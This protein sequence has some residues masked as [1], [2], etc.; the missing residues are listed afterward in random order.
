M[1]NTDMVV[2]VLA[3]GAHPDDVEL[4]VGGL[5]HKLSQHGHVVGILDLTRGE[6]GTRGTPD[7]RAQEAAAAAEIL[8]IARRENVGLPDGQLANTTEQQR[9]IIPLLRSFRARTLLLPQGRDRHPDHRSAYELVRDAAYF[10]GLAKIETGQE[11]YRPEFTYYYH[12]Y[13]QDN[14]T[15]DFV[16]DISEHFEVK[17]AAVSAHASQFYNPDHPGK[18][19]YISSKSFWDTI[20]VRA[21]YWG[22]RVNVAYGEPLS[23]DLPVRLLTLPGLEVES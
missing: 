15:P 23:A 12:P 13:Y 5:L 10:S 20:R 21:A 3:V 1:N 8:G 9:K 11:P 17:L 22:G 16:V 7:E 2:D 19:T 14:A 4:G 18:P 6:M